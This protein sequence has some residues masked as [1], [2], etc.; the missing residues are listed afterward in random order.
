MPEIEIAPNLHQLVERAAGHFLRLL[1]GS[2]RT[3]NRFTLALAGGS[4]PLELYIRLATARVVWDRV[5]FFWGDERCVPPGHPDSNYRMVHEALLKHIPIPKENVHRIQ[6]ERSAPLAA[7]EYQQE[8]QRFFG[9][10]IPR[11]DLVL[12]GLGTDGHTASLF[13]GTPGS[14][15]RK[16]WVLPVRHAIPPPPLVDRVTLSLPVFNAAAQ[17]IFLVAGAGKAAALA[18][19]LTPASSPV[20]FPAQKVCPVKGRL[21]WLVDKA[22]SSGIP[23][24]E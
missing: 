3:S 12:L 11:F 8:L 16:R 21:L 2:L 22:A 5:H 17:V 23:A 9:M 1:D 10:E 6:G 19:V 13:P 15:A 18:K 7:R 14:H 24:S 20:P 4:T